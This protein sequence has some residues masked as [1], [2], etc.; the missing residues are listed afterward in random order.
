[1]H[2]SAVYPRGATIFYNIRP[3]R[4]RNAKAAEFCPWVAGGVPDVAAQLLA[5][6]AAVRY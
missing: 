1:M 2:S 3:G 5:T 4:T 6:A